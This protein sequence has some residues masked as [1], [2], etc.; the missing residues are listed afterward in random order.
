[1]LSIKCFFS[2]SIYLTSGDIWSHELDPFPC[3]K[4]NYPG[5]HPSV[6]GFNQGW[7]HLDGHIIDSQ[8]SRG[9]QGKFCLQEDGEG[10]PGLVSLDV[11]QIFL[12]ESGYFEKSCMWAALSLVYPFITHLHPSHKEAVNEKA[13]VQPSKLQL[14]C[15]PRQSRNLKAKTKREKI[16][17]MFISWDSSFPMPIRVLSKQFTSLPNKVQAIPKQREQIFHCIQMEADDW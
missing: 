1:M 10:R 16:F 6:L 9:R 2:L 7:I 3:S 13:T 15:C 11:A 14:L 5:F 12:Q 17:H 4:E 8:N